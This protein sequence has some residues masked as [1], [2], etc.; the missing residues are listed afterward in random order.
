MRHSILTDD[1]T[2]SFLS[3]RPTED[4]HHCVFGRGRR[5]MAEREGFIVGLT[6]EEHMLVH[7]DRNLQLY[8]IRL[9]QVEYE[10]TGSREQ[11]IRLV[12]KNYL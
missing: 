11:W 2:V 12:G 10:K 1:L 8:F 9:C 5:K 4:V 7:S 3:G 6:H